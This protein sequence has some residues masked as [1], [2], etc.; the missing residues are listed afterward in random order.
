MSKLGVVG[1][2]FPRA[3]LWRALRRL[4]VLVFLSC[5]LSCGMAQAAPRFSGD[6]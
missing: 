5:G 1:V 6:V 4:L 2:V 3:A